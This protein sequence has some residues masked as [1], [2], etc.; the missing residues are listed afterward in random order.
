MAFADGASAYSRGYAEGLMPDPELWIDD[1]SRAHAYIPTEGNAEG[2]KYDL[3]RTP[4]AGGVMRALSPASPTRRVV[5]M[6]ASQLLK[7]QTMMNFLMAVAD[8]APSNA[9]VLMPNGFLAERL[10]L[11]IDNTIKATP[12][13][14]DRFAKPRSRDGKNTNTTKT[15]RGGTLYIATAGSAANLAEIPARYLAGDEIDDWEADIQGQGDPI[16]VLENRASTF[17][18]NAKIY[19]S[20]SPKKPAAFSKILALFQ[21]GNQ[22][23]CHV[24]CPHCGHMH[25]MLWDNM[26]HDDA[27]S[28]AWLVCPDCGGEIDEHHKTAMLAAYAW[29]PMA[30]SE[31]GTESFTISQL[32]AQLG[33]TS[34]LDLVR[35]HRAAIEAKEKGDSTKIRAFWNTRLALCYDDTEEAGSVTELHQRAQAEAIPSRVIPDR[36]IVLTAFADTQPNRLEVSIEAWG[37]G[38]EHWTL[39]HITLWGSPTESPESPTSVWRQL[40]IIR[41]T[42][43]AHASGR[44]LRI[45]AYGV[46]TGGHNTQDVYNY[47]AKRAHL[48]CIATKGHSLR[49][50]PIIASK[51]TSQDINWEGERVTDGVRLWMIG[52]DTAKDWVF[53]RLRLTSGDGAPHWSSGL[54]E[55][56][57]EGL[58]SEVAQVRWV[59]GVAVREWVK[60]ANGI[61]NEPLDCLVGNLAVAYYLGLHKWSAADWRNR[62]AAM[63]PAASTPDLFAAADASDLP[64]A[65]HDADLPPAPVL[66]DAPPPA[67]APIAIPARLP[68]KPLPLHHKPAARRV[69]MLNRGTRL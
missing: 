3:D 61:R 18:R 58:L 25:P 69:G 20:S 1:W 14:R 46:D 24:P 54:D 22:Q 48:G 67:P 62:R 60:R 59:K 23:H 34:W 42:P 7:T 56:Y 30:E 9:L 40:D 4:F 8:H 37:P 10:A 39:D 2:G 66:A 65:D 21:R 50:R 55:D 63:I 32:Y 47:A 26:R 43:F 45:S 36:A 13:V 5:V 38:L 35:L 27:M 31:D 68:S 52:T 44:L 51:P 49:G 19:Y 57:F 15:F 17:G 64:P 33:W 41:K 16:E 29:V 12:R 11:R 28:R 53:G 6:G